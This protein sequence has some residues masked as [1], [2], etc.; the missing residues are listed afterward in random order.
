[1]GYDKKWA[2]SRE[3]GTFDIYI[4]IYIYIFLKEL[5]TSSI[6]VGGRWVGSVHIKWNGPSICNVW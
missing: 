3:G 4:Y 1:M 5:L 6:G 2:I